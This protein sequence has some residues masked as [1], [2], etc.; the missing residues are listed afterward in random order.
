MKMV[1]AVMMDQCTL[2][3]WWMNFL[4]LGIVLREEPT[5]DGHH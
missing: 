2:T 4:V 5:D 3:Y 1:E